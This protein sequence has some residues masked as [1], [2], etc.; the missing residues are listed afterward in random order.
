MVTLGL[1]MWCQVR[2]HLSE[3][4]GQPPD[5]GEDESGADLGALPVAA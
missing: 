3:D 1:Y 5:S 2:R 4:E